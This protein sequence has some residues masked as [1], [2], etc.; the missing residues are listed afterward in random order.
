MF[1]RGGSRLFRPLRSPGG[2]P[3]GALPG[4]EVPFGA[5]WSGGSPILSFRFVCPSLV[6][7]IP[8]GFSCG[9][10]SPFFRC[11]ALLFCFPPVRFFPSVRSLVVLFLSCFLFARSCLVLGE[12]C[13]LRPMLVRGFLVF[14]VCWAAA[15]SFLVRSVSCVVGVVF[16]VFWL[17]LAWGVRC[18]SFWGVV[19]VFSVWFWC[20][21]ALVGV[22]VCCF[23]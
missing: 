23:A 9:S 19:A 3:S 6:S 4:S 10:Y 7:A 15:G 8:S 2:L 13:F 1:R 20:C 17:G 12:L 5:L 11:A 21:C 18:A 22:V 16:V 14:G